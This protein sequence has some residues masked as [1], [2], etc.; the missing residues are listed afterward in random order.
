MKKLFILFLLLTGLHCTAM[1][2]NDTTGVEIT[3]IDSYITPEV[4]HT[5]V[6]SFFTSDS[7]TASLKL[8]N[9][10]IYKVSEKPADSHKIEVDLTSLKFDSLLIHYTITAIDK[11]KKKYSQSFETILSDES[12]LVANKD[13]NLFNICCMGGTIFGL[14]S[15]TYVLMNGKDYFALSKEIPL[16]SFYSGGYNYPSS[17]L[18]VEYKYIPKFEAKHQLGV[19]Y[20][21][22]FQLPVVEYAAPGAGYFTNFLGNYGLSFETSIGLFKFYNV[23]TVY[24]RYRYNQF[25]GDEK[26]HFHEISIGLYSNFFSLNL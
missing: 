16:F 10:Y 20:K 26:S 21:Y 22:V 25:I 23:F 19:G 17:Y 15:P 6:L 5:F 8:G 7:C 9:K 2:Q 12:L 24:T 3:I 14:P 13:L 1:A 11:D 4:P 18:S